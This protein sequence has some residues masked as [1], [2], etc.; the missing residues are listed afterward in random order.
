MIAAAPIDRETKSLCHVIAHWLLPWGLIQDKNKMLDELATQPATT[1]GRLYAQA[2]SRYGKKQLAEVVESFAVQV[3]DLDAQYRYHLIRYPTPPP[4][5][6][7][8]KKG[9]PRPGQL[10]APLFSAVIEN[11]HT[12]RLRYFVLEQAQDGGSTL[13]AIWSHMQ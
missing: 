1:L 2:C 6:P 12:H 3:G 13:L 5:L 7:L 4:L 10:M 11:V 8:D 9:R